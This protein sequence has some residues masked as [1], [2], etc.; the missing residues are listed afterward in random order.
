MW[1]AQPQIAKSPQRGFGAIGSGSPRRPRGHRRR[2]RASAENRTALGRLHPQSRTTDGSCKPVIG[3]DPADALLGLDA[4][5]IEVVRTCI[6]VPSRPCRPSGCQ[7]RAVQ[8]VA[9]REVE[10]GKGGRARKPRLRFQAGA[11]STINFSPIGGTPSSCRR[12]PWPEFLKATS[13]REN[14]ESREPHRRGA[15]PIGR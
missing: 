10:I 5:P 11:S 8:S 15:P 12:D 2:H 14:V 13:E 1:P 4:N 9:A 3:P 6:V 7:R